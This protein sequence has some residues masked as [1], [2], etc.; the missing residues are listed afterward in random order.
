[1][2]FEFANRVGPVVE[3]RGSQRGIGLAFGEHAH[4]II[5]LPR[6]ARRNHGNV[7][8]AGNG[9][10]KG[11]GRQSAKPQAANLVGAAACGLER[12]NICQG[13]TGIE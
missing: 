5:R 12:E 11:G 1:M 13:R 3:D 9:A 6:A 2:F 4:K 8:G 10:A 7:R